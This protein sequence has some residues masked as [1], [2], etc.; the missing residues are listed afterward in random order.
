MDNLKKIGIWLKEQIFKILMLIGTA[1]IIYYL[2]FI[3]KLKEEFPKVQ[4]Q[5]NEMQRNQSE[6]NIAHQGK[7]YVIYKWMTEQ[8]IA[9]SIKNLKH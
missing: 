3:P 1:V 9:D 7:I 8:R 6:I 4:D 2:S 5:L